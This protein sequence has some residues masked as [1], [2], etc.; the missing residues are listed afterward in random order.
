MVDVGEGASDNC[1]HL[2]G[3]R[4]SSRCLMLELHLPV[5]DDSKVLLILYHLNRHI[6][7]VVG[8]FWVLGANMQHLALR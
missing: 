7:Q 2:G 5:N 4:N 8:P 3:L 6:F 1:E